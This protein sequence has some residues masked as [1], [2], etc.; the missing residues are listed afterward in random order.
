MLNRLTVSA[1]L[2]SV[3]GL[4]AIGVVGTLAVSAWDS[5]D[6]V[7]NAG[8][9]SVIVDAS[10]NLFKAMHNLRNDRSSTGR[11]LNADTTV[12]SEIEKY[13]LTTQDNEM[14][15][16]RSAAAMLAPVS[17]DGAATL[18]PSLVQSTEKLARLHG[19]ARDAMH[20]PKA[21]RRPALPKEYVETITALIETL[22]KVSSQL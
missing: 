7:R 18:L 19:E 17:F 1:L 13:I 14:S 16:L 8:R 5:W 2:K 12:Q 9:I 22:E 11:I 4:M 15:A 20:K 21:A 10:S 6:Q 3:I